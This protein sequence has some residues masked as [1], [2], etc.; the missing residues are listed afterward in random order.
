MEVKMDAPAVTVKRP[1]KLE[2]KVGKDGSGH[3]RAVNEAGD[4]LASLMTIS[5]NGRSIMFTPMAR[6]FLE[7][8]NVDTS[9]MPFDSRGAWAPRKIS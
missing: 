9:E 6:D 5:P 8:H 3:L 7:I 1:L 2:L 4:W